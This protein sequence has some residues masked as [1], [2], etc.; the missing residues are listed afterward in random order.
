MADLKYGFLG[1]ATLD[2]ATEAMLY[3]VTLPA[4]VGSF[5]V[6][7]VN[8]NPTP[9]AIY[10]AHGTG[11]NTAAADT[12]FWEHSTILKM[13][14]PMERTALVLNTGRKVFAF[15][16]RP[17]VDVSIHGFEQGKP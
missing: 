8:K 12:L 16:D 6:T 1:G 5:T 7:F 4:I 15:S 14:E 17:G 13:G 3:E 11:A 2:G 9:A 10:L